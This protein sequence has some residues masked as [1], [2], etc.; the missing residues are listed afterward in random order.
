MR[1]WVLPVTLGLLAVSALAWGFNQYGLRRGLETYLAGRYQRSFYELMAHVQSV[2]ILLA[3]ALVASDQQAALLSDIWQQAS[4]AQEDLTQL[5]LGEDV[6]GRTAR[7]LTQVADYAQSFLRRNTT[8]EAEWDNL[9]RLYQQAG[10]LNRELHNI[11]ANYGDP[12]TYFTQ[13]TRLSRQPEGQGPA[14]AAGF[15]DIDRTMQGYPTLVYDGPFSEH[16][17]R[18]EPKGLGKEK[19]D[20]DGAVRRALGFL[21]PEPGARYNGRASGTVRAK[22]PAWRVE[23]DPAPGSPGSRAVVDVSEQ[24]GQVV[25]MLVLRPAGEPTL[26]VDQ[27]RNKATQFLAARGYPPMEVTYHLQ[28]GNTVT[29]NMAPVQNGV[30]LYPDLVKVTVALDNGQVVGLE[31]TGY[32]FNHHTRELPA[33]RVTRAAAKAKLSPRLEVSG[34]RLALIPTGGGGEKLTYEFLAK[35]NEDAFLI[36]T[37]ALTG[38]QEKILKLIPLPGGTLTM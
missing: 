15:R 7:F 25:W 20:A 18:Q 16:L 14:M 13:L 6:I 11:E 3:K 22:I 24:G 10:A 31:S 5:P 9:Q 34:G 8:I 26:S 38:R 32:L 33:P 37:D 27:A 1:K 29:F 28:Q 35:L 12:R 36:Y 21:D 19:I 30:V 23:V 4:A 2:E 17:E